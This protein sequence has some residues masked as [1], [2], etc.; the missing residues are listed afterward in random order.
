LQ[1]L[2]R[3]RREQANINA[4][5]HAVGWSGLFNGFGG[6]DSEKTSPVDLLPFKD[7]VGKPEQKIS[8]RTRQIILEAIKERSIS[9]P[10]VSAI[11]L[12]L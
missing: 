10:I 6:K 7:E 8:D 5:T 2:E 3:D 12:L 11:A 1:E 9:P 4:Y